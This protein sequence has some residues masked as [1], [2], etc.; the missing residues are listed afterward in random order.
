MWYDTNQEKRKILADAGDLLPD[1]PGGLDG[2]EYVLQNI[3]NT[4]LK[5]LFTYNSKLFKLEASQK[6][7]TSRFLTSQT[8]AWRNGTL[9]RFT[10]H[11]NCQRIE[12]I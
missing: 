2:G 1:G 9:D 5:Q 6:P 10:R 4:T 7:T 3:K 8:C 12:T 11:S